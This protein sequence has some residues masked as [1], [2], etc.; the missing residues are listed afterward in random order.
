MGD[1]HLGLLRRPRQFFYVKAWMEWLVVSNPTRVG[2][3]IP[4]KLEL[5]LLYKLWAKATFSSFELWTAWSNL[6]LFTFSSW[7]ALKCSFFRRKMGCDNNCPKKP[8]KSD[9]HVYWYATSS[10]TLSAAF[11]KTSTNLSSERFLQ[12]QVL[13]CVARHLKISLTTSRH[14]SPILLPGRF[15]ACR[16]RRFLMAFGSRTFMKPAFFEARGRLPLS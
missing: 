2:A 9:A 15:C 7:P 1:A 14:L 5:T 4:H 8:C 12:L 13:L 16:T 3:S 10:Q 11:C 6:N